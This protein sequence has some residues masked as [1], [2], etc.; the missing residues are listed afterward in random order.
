MARSRRRR[1]RPRVRVIVR[2]AAIQGPLDDAAVTPGG[3]SLAYTSSP[4]TG[5]DGSR[6]SRCSS[7]STL[8]TLAAAGAAR[9]RKLSSSRSWPASVGTS[10]DSMTPTCRRLHSKTD[11]D[12]TI[13]VSSTGT[14]F[15]PA[16]SSPLRLESLKHDPLARAKSARSNGVRCRS[17]AVVISRGRL[18][19]RGPRGLSSSGNLAR[20]D[21]S[22][23][24]GEGPRGGADGSWRR[25]RRPTRSAIVVKRRTVSPRTTA[26]REVVRYSTS[27]AR[28]PS[29]KTL[30]SSVFP[31][32]CAIRR[33]RARRQTSGRRARASRRALGV[34]HGRGSRSRRVSRSRGGDDGMGRHPASFG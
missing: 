20:I 13:S 4:S 34:H 14:R 26:P 8:P 17:T 24:D 27:S 12:A 18:P 21:A 11:H 23:V 31:A 16:R 15:D 1:A 30:R 7:M 22:I 10:D 3:G 19:R 2:Y 28:I 9:D 6:S 32:R 33:A 5:M 25:P 29:A